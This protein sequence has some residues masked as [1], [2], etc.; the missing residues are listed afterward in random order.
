MTDFTPFASIAEAYM[1]GKQAVKG[2]F[3]LDEG[4]DGNALSEEEKS[5]LRIFCCNWH[6]KSQP[7][8]NQLCKFLVSIHKAEGITAAELKVDPGLTITQ[9]VINSW[10]QITLSQHQL[11]VEGVTN[12]SVKIFSSPD[13]EAELSA[14]VRKKRHETQLMTFNKLQALAADKLSR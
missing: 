8:S 9:D 3:V 12:T 11:F 7:L 1:K 14:T 6:A 13:I 10:H 4:M 2:S 5:Y